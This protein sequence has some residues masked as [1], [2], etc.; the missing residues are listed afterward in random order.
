MFE[1]LFGAIRTTEF[2]W[3]YWSAELFGAVR[4]TEAFVSV[5]RRALGMRWGTFS[6]DD[7]IF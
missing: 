4:A 3:A 2:L 5:P 1:D 6:V 7:D